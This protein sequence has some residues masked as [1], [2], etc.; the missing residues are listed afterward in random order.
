MSSESRFIRAQIPVGRKKQGAQYHYNELLEVK[1]GECAFDVI[2][3]W[4]KRL[5]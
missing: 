1:D 2:E 3:K 5:I 4:R